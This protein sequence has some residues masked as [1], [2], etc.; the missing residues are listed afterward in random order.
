MKGETETAGEGGPEHVADD[1]RNPLVDCPDCGGDGKCT[2]K[3]LK[4]EI[5]C[6][7]CWGEGKIEPFWPRTFHGADFP[8]AA[9][10]PIRPKLLLGRAG[11]GDWVKVRPCDPALG[12]KTYLGVLLGEAAMGVH[13]SYVRETRR[14]KV[15]CGMRNP[16]IY[17]PDLK[18]V[19]YGVESWWGK[20]ETPDDLCEITD[21]VVDDVWYV[22]A[23]KELGGAA[24]ARVIS[25]GERKA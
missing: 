11:C 4:H 14:L 25:S 1:G 10:P 2:S 24:D 5:S 23:L 13:L 20:I 17:V 15:T 18:R 19:V 12:G 6:P 8:D 21:A 9:D 3:L 16:A 7:R 22:R